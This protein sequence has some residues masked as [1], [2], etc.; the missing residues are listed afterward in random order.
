[1]INHSLRNIFAIHKNSIN[2]TTKYTNKKR[3]K[4]VED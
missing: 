3:K 4:T 1:M 2:K